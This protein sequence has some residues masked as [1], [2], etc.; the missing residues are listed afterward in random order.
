MP[1][2]KSTQAKPGLVF[3][4]SGPSGSGKT[5]LAKQVLKCPQLKNKFVRSISFTTRPK[6]TG[7]RQG[8]DY[9]F[10]SSAEFKQLLKTK[11]ILEYTCYLGYDYG[12][13]RSCLEQAIKRGRNIILCLDIKGASFV[14]E[15]YPHTAVT[16]FVKPPS[17]TEAKKRIFARST[18]ITPDEINSRIKL[19]TKEL[20]HSKRFDY[21]VINDD[22]KKSVK[23][24]KGIIQWAIFQ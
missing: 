4:L 12:T 11:K 7:E 22:L 21:C 13:S 23:E 16:I 18:K 5:T 24:V 20:S 8:R 15:H 14:K 2:R 19:A 6:R 3:V 10:V 1:R 9:F 17:L